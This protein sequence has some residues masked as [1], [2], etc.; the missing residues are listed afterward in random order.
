M[1]S[2]ARFSFRVFR[3]PY[4]LLSSLLFVTL[5][6]AAELPTKSP[7]NVRDF[8][9]TGDGTTKDTIAFQKALDTCAVHGGGEVLVPAGKYLIGSIQLGTRTILRLEKDS[10]LTGSPDLADYPLIDI[11]WEGR[12]QPGHRS[13]IYAA[14]VDH[15]GIVGPGLIE[16]NPATA[17]SNRPPRGTLVLEPINCTDV[18]WEGFSVRQTGNNWATHPTYCSDVVIKNVTIY[19]GRDGIDVDSCSRVRIEGCE[20]NTGDDSISLKSG[21]G[22]DGARIGRPTEDVLITH[23][24]MTGRR[25]ACIGIG[26]EISAGVRNIRIEHCKFTSA[27][28]AIYLKTR[29]GRAGVNENISGDDLEILGGGF[30]RINLTVGGN[31]NTSDDPVEGLIG[32]PSAK[33]I[34]FN[35]V[36]LT[37]A[38][39][40][41]EATQTSPAKP[42]EGLTLTN[43]TGTAKKGLALANVTGAVLRDITVTGVEGPLLATEN[44]TGTGL[45]HA[46]DLPGRVTLWNGKDLT[47]WKLFLGDATIDPA[48]VWSVS[49]GVLQLHTKASGYL[50]TE[51]PSA[52][53][54]LHAEWRW[55]KDAVANSNSGILLHVHGDDAVWPLCF[56]AQMK[57]G[58][59]GQVVG[60]GLD[61]PAAPLLANRKRAPRLADVSE[62]PHGEWNS[63]DLYVSKDTI[64]AY[65]N[66][67]RQ[68]RVEQ[69]P[70]SAGMIALQL[71]G[72][73]VEF[74]NIWLRP[75]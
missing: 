55:P 19:G 6:P 37:H 24:T 72:F 7:F 58:N 26:S 70:S 9:A 39:V 41:V 13:L 8:G 65:V 56:E 5:A 11:R 31:T 22:L 44:V 47:G 35:N 46:A 3:G 63:Y 4:L 21:R 14:N 12:W 33:N 18:R 20:I 52:N 69:L 74:R 67:V 59:A 45:E 53:Y 32:Y 57:T 49:D 62:K 50:R 15:T 60:M 73:P 66:G 71:E 36:R 61:I 2:S 34:R 43:I 10:V 25:F 64:E 40:V 23:C 28:H 75:L 1:L 51:K 17:A 68:N 54:R 16:G 42:I 38:T 48:S 30:L 27:S 29:I